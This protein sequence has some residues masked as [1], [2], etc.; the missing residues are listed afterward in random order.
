M[1]YASSD[2]TGQAEP[3]SHRLRGVDFTRLLEQRRDV[4]SRPVQRQT[5]AL[6][7]RRVEQVA[8]E[9]VHAADGPRHDGE[10]PRAT[11]WREGLVEEH[12]H[13]RGDAVQRI[14][15]VVRDDGQHAIAQL[16]GGFL[17]PQGLREPHAL[18]CQRALCSD[19]L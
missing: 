5:A 6:N 8:D 1:R 2:V 4:D 19:E 14:S 11:F 15:Q 13:A 12:G 10:Q 3:L 7:A 9:T 16:D 17:Y 18:L